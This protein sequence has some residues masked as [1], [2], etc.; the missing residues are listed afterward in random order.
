MKPELRLAQMLLAGKTPQAI[1]ASLADD[2]DPEMRAALLRHAPQLPRLRA[3]LDAARIDHVAC[4]TPADFAAAFDRAAAVSAEAGVALYSLGDPV[5]LA[6]ASAEIAVW[7]RQRQFVRPAFTVLDLGCG[8]GRMTAALRDQAAFVAGADI[9]A[10]MLR[11]ARKRLPQGAFIR[12]TGFDLACFREQ[13]VDLVLAVDC[14]P[15]FFLTS[16]ELADRHIAEAARVLRPGGALAVLNFSYRGD[17]A[18]DCRD[19]RHWSTRHG[20][21]LRVCGETPFQ[22]WDAAAFV[23]LRL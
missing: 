16:P 8:I 6:A 10:G 11:A 19:F 22:S 15:Y 20:L 14:F 18:Q 5:S 21:A 17:P 9:S 1:A 13:S 7:L 23:G 2:P 12:H 4:A 3:M